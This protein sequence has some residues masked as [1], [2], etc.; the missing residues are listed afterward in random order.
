[1]C[2]FYTSIRPSQFMSD[3]P[4]KEEILFMY[5]WLYNNNKRKGDIEGCRELHNKILAIQKSKNVNICNIENG[6]SILAGTVAGEIPREN[7]K[8]VDGKQI[9]IPYSRKRL[10]LSGLEEIAQSMILTD[11]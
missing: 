10:T 4:S 8:I 11:N 3:N 7:Y 5:E 9:A 1:M 6:I 2:K